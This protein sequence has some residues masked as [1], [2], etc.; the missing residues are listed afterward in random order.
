M[1]LTIRSSAI[2]LLLIFC[3]N[4]KA[5][6]RRD[7]WLQYGGGYTEAGFALSL[8][9]A[10]DSPLGG[11]AGTFKPAPAVNLNALYYLDNF[12]AD[13]GVGYRSYSPKQ[14]VF[15]YDDGAGS[16]TWDS[17]PVY[18]V[19][20]GGAYNIQVNNLFNAYAGADFGVCFTDYSYHSVDQFTDITAV[21]YAENLS[22][23]PKV[24]ANFL[25]NTHV[26]IGIEGK[27]NIFT[28]TG[29]SDTDPFV[30][31]VYKTYALGVLATYR[32]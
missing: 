26:G 3:F 21:I 28:P 13:V 1:S 31:T 19:Y 30:G 10:Y 9:T 27:F 29:S 11:F 7:P 14:A 16:I 32:F 25:V 5:Q 24:G 23:S 6:R 2:V 20:L 18:S 15:Y 12:V 8:S 22:V 17:F 4:A